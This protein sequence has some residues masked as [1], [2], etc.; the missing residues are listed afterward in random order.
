MVANSK[1]RSNDNGEPESAERINWRRQ[2]IVRPS[3]R[4]WQS[5][6]WTVD[7][8]FGERTFSATRIIC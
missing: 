6:D 1:R 8:R 5:D 3:K 2:T 4:P 7:G